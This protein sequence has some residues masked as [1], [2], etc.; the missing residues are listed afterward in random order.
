MSEAPLQDF[1]STHWASQNGPFTLVLLM[2]GLLV[3]GYLAHKKKKHPPR[4]PLGPWA[5]AYGR[6]LGEY[7]FFVIEAPLYTDI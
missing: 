4:T 7:V 3:Q 5:Y 1:W 6:V 2:L